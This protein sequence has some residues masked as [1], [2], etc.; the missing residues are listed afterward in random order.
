MHVS[1]EVEPRRSSDAVASRSRGFRE[2]EILDYFNPEH[3]KA[4]RIDWVIVGW[5][6]VMH[7]GALA[8]PFFFTW[9][10]FFAFL[11]LYWLTGSIGV[12]LGYHRFLSHRG[13]KLAAPLRFFVSLCGCLSVE[14][15][16]LTWAATHRL[17]HA[18]SD[19][20]GDPHSPR[21]G[22]WWSHINWLFVR[23][24]P[25]QE[26]TLHQRFC[27]DLVDDPI[28]RL[29]EKTFIYWS[30]ALGALLYFIGG[31]PMVLWGM[32]LRLVV[33]YHSTWLVNSATHLWGY[34]SYETRDDSRNNWLVAVVSWG[35]G[36]HNNH[37][38]YPRLA[39]A[40]HRW[41]EVDVTWWVIKALRAAGLAWEVQDK[42]PPR[43]T[44][45]V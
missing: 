32:C 14:G 37:H 29:F 33:M 39:R 42:L 25:E 30:L 13:L 24:T 8:A 45:T 17:H 40:G 1:L 6:A 44:S 41:W 11:V 20:P 15:S 31:L 34:R 12:C 27:P 18:R 9:P 35:E 2:A 3:L 26:A 5:M 22:K 10:A 23:H 7:G 21:D 19:Q 43:A 28:M 16:P 4:G 36:W 38:A